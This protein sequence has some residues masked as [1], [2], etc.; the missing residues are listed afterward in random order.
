MYKHH[1]G[2]TLPPYNQN[3]YYWSCIIKPDE[4]P[5][6]MHIY[7]SNLSFLS[8]FNQILLIV[9]ENIDRQTDRQ[10][11][12]DN[13]ITVY[14]KHEWA[15]KN[16][17]CKT[18]KGAKKNMKGQLRMFWVKNILS[19]YLNQNTVCILNGTLLF[20]EITPQLWFPWHQQQNES[21]S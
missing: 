20:P 14:A 6:D 7:T 15:A 2:Y 8:R 10:A 5:C 1:K 13:L 12:G 21:S 16:C 4:L 3:I 9:H 11:D 17:L 18:L 19:P